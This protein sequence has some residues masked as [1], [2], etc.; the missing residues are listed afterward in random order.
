[1]PLVF[2]CAP[3]V[4]TFVTMAMSRTFMEAGPI[5]YAG[6]IVAA[7]GAAGVMFFKPV[8]TNI[9]V[10]EHKDGKVTISYQDIAHN[11]QESWG[12]ITLEELRSGSYDKALGLYNRTRPL[13]ARQFGL[14]LAS[15]GLTAV[16]WGAYGPMLHKGQ[17]KMGGSRMRPFLC[18][19]LSYFL[20]AVLVPLALMPARSQ[21][22][23]VGI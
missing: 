12:P 16:C 14:V 21:N 20:I 3:V 6:V 7:T 18:V 8:A 13:S 23:A 5:F 2:G 15:I 9:Q 4:N 19:G 22:Q 10:E 1:M 11:H 17:M